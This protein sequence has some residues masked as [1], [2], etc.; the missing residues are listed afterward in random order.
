[1]IS[2]SQL[3]IA[4][5]MLRDNLQN[6]RDARV[7]L[8][9]RELGEELTFTFFQMLR[10]HRISQVAQRNR[11]TD[12]SFRQHDKRIGFTIAV[13]SNLK[14]IPRP[15]TMGRDDFDVHRLSMTRSIQEVQVGV[16]TA[17]KVDQRNRLVFD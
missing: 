13:D 1:M 11:P 14:V 5:L 8:V 2:F 7:W 16:T 15:Q 9:R 3:P 12:A 10:P 4:A 17:A 6:A